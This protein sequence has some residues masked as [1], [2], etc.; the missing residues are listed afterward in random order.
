MWCD[1][2][3]IFTSAVLPACQILA[4]NKCFMWCVQQN[5][6]SKALLYSFYFLF[7][8]FMILTDIDKSEGMFDGTKHALLAFSAFFFFF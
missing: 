3:A 8:L 1:I 5:P 7:T 2:G 6:G 4:V